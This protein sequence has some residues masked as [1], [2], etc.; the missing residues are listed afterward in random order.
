MWS[1]LRE[2]FIWEVSLDKEVAVRFRK[3]FGSGSGYGNLRGNFHHGGTEEIQYILLII[4]QAQIPIKTFRGGGMSHW[5]PTVPFWCCSESWPG[6]R[7][8]STQFLPL[9]DRASCKVFASNSIDKDYNAWRRFA[10]SECRCYWRPSTGLA[11]LCFYSETGFWL[12][13]C[14]ISTDLDKILHTP[15]VVR[16]ALVGRLRLRSARGR[17]QAKPER[18][19]L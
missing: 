14:Q 16:N 17:L 12:S 18:L 5:Q 6:S 19:F 15:I 3:S 9:R 11:V 7:N 4:T 8:F 1:D 2:N 13:Y 10:L